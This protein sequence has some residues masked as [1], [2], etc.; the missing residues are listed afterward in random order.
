MK[1]LQA[2]KYLFI[3]RGAERYLSELIELLRERGHDVIP[4]T[5]RHER[6]SEMGYIGGYD[7]Y[8]VSS[9]DY[10]K[11]MKS[12]TLLERLRTGAKL[13]YSCE[14]R[15]KMVRL[16][17]DTEPDLAHIHNIYYQLTP[18][19]LPVIRSRGIPV[20]M[21]VH[22]YKLICPS[23]FLFSQGE[24]C[25]RC[26]KHRYYMAVVR[27]CLK[28]SYSASMLGAI[29]LS[30]HNLLGLYRKNIDLFIAPSRFL[31]SKIIEWG[32]DGSRVVHLPYCINIADYHPNSDSH[33]RYILYA[34]ALSP[35]KG[36]DVLV[37]AMQR[38]DSVELRI[39]GRGEDEARLK[40][41]ARE[42]DVRNVRFLGFMHGEELKEAV[43]N[44]LCTIV[45][46]ICYD[47]SPLAV[48]ESMALGK[49]VIA[50]RIGGIPELVI[51][52]RTGFLFEPGNF[53]E[54]AEKIRYLIGMPET[55]VDM[56]RE[57]RARLEREYSPES[58]Y[59]ALMGI[60]RRVL[61]AAE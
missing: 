36:V 7:G 24:I 30:V 26:K 15:K 54:L 47:N 58:H 46:S 5:M 4:F 20:V 38:V 39:L 27:K 9:I 29:E 41:L 44:A 11:T 53:R 28:S 19:I 42:L 48:F 35:E 6:N 59:R 1:I 40:A 33:E 37:R 8:H 12:G 55:I 25:E 56:G 17:D 16:L 49:P 43:R 21:T 45:P 10:E 14:A 18:S 50:S 60:Y 31:R 32:M 22:D 13:I 23:N 57:A 61:S 34:G 3:Y 52:G 2:N 51:D